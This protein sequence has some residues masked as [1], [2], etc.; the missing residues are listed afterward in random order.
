MRSVTARR[1]FRFSTAEP[2]AVL[3]YDNQ[4]SMCDYWLGSSPL[5]TSR[6]P[7]SPATF[8]EPL[9]LGTPSKETLLEFRTPSRRYGYTALNLPAGITM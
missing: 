2:R 4:I 3:Q 9:N 1:D 8:I 5:T 7:F 6:S